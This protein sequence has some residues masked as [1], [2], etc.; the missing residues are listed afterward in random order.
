MCERG[1]PIL[2]RKTHT[3]K[4]GSGFHPKAVVV[5]FDRAV[6]GRAVRAGRFNHVF[7]VSESGVLK[8]KALGEF[9]ALVGAYATAI[10]VSM[11]CKERRDDIDRRVFAGG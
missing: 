11:L 5:D 2:S 8:G 6:L 9:A 7:V 4:E 3:I 1:R 10:G